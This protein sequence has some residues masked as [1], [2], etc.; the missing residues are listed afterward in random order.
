MNKNF[1][2]GENVRVTSVNDGEGS[3]SEQFTAGGTQLDVV[4]SVV[5]DVALGQHGVVLELRLSERRGVC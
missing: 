3:D 2:G 1:L 4:S 5:V